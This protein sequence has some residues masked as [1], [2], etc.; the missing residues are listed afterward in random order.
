MQQFEKQDFSLF[1]PVE[2]VPQA[3]QDLRTEIFPIS[4]PLQSAPDKYK[5]SF[6]GYDIEMNGPGTQS[7]S[8]RLCVYW[9]Q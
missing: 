9:W 7:S 2:S 6:R 3:P 5:V 8:E 1:W 4:V